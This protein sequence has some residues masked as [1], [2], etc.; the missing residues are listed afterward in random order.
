MQ[1]I[2]A[3]P[4][5]TPPTNL[6]AG[7]AG[8]R[9]GARAG[10]IDAIVRAVAAVQAGRVEHAGPRMLLALQARVACSGSHF[11]TIFEAYQIY[12]FYYHLGLS[13]SYESE[14]II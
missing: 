14:V 8:P 5:Q 1:P 11:L 13:S 3:R 10:G 12:F 6:L 2:N 4:S 7:V 9:I